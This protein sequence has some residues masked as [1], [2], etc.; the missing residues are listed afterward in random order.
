MAEVRDVAI[1]GAGPA[2]IAAATYLKRAGLD[3]L[4][5]ECGE[6]GGLIW[7]ANLVENYPGFSQGIAG[8]D[9]ARRFAEHLRRLRVDVRREEVKNLSLRTGL[10]RIKTAGPSSASKMVIVASGTRATPPEIPGAAALLGKRVFSEVVAVPYA[11]SRGR[12]AIVLGGGDAALDYALS[13]DERGYDV[14]ILMRS[15]PTCLPLLLERAADRGIDLRRGVRVESV[16]RDGD[17]IQVRCSSRGRPVALHADL[18]L[19]AFGRSPNMDFMDPGLRRHV[20]APRNPPETGVPGLFVA[21]D[22]IRGQNRQAGI[23]IGDGIL[24]AMLVERQHRGGNA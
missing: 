11:K 2:G 13:L 8:A 23:A 20:A 15:N 22:V 5:F 21:G 14:T 17:G 7:N 6:P 3:P 10:F 16:K 4:V 18:L 1:I 19:A 12:S 9:L 24:A